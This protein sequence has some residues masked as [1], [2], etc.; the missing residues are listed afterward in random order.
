MGQ[1]R[2]AKIEYA[3]IIDHPHH[4]SLKHPHM[5]LDDRAAQF[6]AYDALAGY[7]DMIAEEERLTDPEQEPDETA[8]EELDRKLARLSEKLEAGL[9]PRLRFTVF[10]PDR[11][12]A[13]GH[14]E[15][16]TDKLRQIDSV[17]RLL[18][19]EGRSG[20]GGL[21]RTLEIA[22]VTAMEEAPE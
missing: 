12:K 7:F 20:R 1:P 4:R 3:D 6:A 5:P 2:D 10:V 19:L 11:W 9:R 8:K 15:E 13:G 18:V 17:K 14:Y 21:H 22:R 16:I